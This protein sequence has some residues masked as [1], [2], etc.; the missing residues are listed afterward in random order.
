MSQKEIKL[1]L[2]CWTIPLT[3]FCIHGNWG[4]KL[5]D[6]ITLVCI[7]PPFSPSLSFSLSIFLFLCPLICVW[8]QAESKTCLFI[9]LA[10]IL[11]L[12]SFLSCSYFFYW[13]QR[14]SYKLYK[15]LNHF[16]FVSLTPCLVYVS[17]PCHPPF[18]TPSGFT[19]LC[20]P[21]KKEGW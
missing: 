4:H 10:S 11:V 13:P 6:I 17:P 12:A 18:L 15:P 19:L 3:W 9:S 1:F 7:H 21:D 2:K 20:L 5:D 14:H 8:A 16:S